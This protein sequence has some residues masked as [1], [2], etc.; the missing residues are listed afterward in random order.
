[1]ELLLG[2]LGEPPVGCVLLSMAG[3]QQILCFNEKERA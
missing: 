3:V 1:M 2:K